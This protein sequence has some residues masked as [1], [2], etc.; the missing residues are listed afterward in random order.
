MEAEQYNRVVEFSSNPH[1]V[2]NVKGILST[3]GKYVF[4]DRRQF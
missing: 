3:R 4:I 2:M 1:R